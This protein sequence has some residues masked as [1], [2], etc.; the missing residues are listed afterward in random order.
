MAMNVWLFF[1]MID[2]LQIFSKRDLSILGWGTFLE[3]YFRREVDLLNGFL[4]YVLGFLIISF[5]TGFCSMRYFSLS[6]SIN[7]LKL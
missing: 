3:V 5:L 7:A 2:P 1:F 6:R 4:C